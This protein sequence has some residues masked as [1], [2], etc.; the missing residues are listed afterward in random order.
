[1]PSTKKRHLVKVLKIKQFLDSIANVKE[2]KDLLE[3]KGRT[4][5]LYYHF[6]FKTKMET[7]VLNVVGQMKYDGVKDI[8]PEREFRSIIFKIEERLSDKNCPN[9]I[10]FQRLLVAFRNCL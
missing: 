10:Y 4:R 3:I 2:D 8:E 6:Y 5:S 1:M 9:R 7:R